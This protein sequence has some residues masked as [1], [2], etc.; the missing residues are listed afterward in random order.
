MVTWREPAVDFA[1]AGAWAFQVIYVKFFNNKTRHHKSHNS[2]SKSEFNVN[3]VGA[4]GRHGGP[5]HTDL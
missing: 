3:Y 1:A 2:V 4:R 5:A